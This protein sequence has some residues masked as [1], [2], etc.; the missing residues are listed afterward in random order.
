MVVMLNMLVSIMTDTFD[1]VSEHMEQSRYK[2]ICQMIS[3]LGFVFNREE[4][5]KDTKYIIVVS[6]EKVKSYAAGWE[7]KIGYLK[8]QID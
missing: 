3:D 6:L 7:G 2:E 8:S 1:K 4:K 5:F